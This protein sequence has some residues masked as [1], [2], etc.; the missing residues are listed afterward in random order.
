MKTWRHDWRAAW[1]L[2]RARLPALFEIARRAAWQARRDGA[3]G[4]RTDHRRNLLL[5]PGR[6]FRPSAHHCHPGTDRAEC[7]KPPHSCIW[8][9]GCATGEERTIGIL[10]DREFGNRLANWDV[11]IL[12]SDITNE[13]LTRAKAASYSEWAFRATPHDVREQ[14]FERRGTTWALRPKYR[15]LVTF[16]R[17][18]LAADRAMASLAT[19]FDFIFCRNVMIYFANDL[20]N[21]RSPDSGIPSCRADGSSWAT[22]SLTPPSS[23]G[24]HAYRQGTRASIGRAFWARQSASRNRRPGHFYPIREITTNPRGVASENPHAP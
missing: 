19:T 20:I 8:S 7:R 18:N 4:W 22:R 14:C 1:G 11:S 3:P 24:S 2:E 15:K 13:F 23:P 17:L 9:A 21:E 6:A 16:Q 10:L 12:A 5:P